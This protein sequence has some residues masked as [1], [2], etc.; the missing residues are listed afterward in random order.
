MRSLVAALVAALALVACSSDADPAPAAKACT[1]GA[2]QVCSG[3]GACVG[4]QACNAEGTAFGAC[5]C[6]AAGGAGAGGSA[7]GG[8]EAGAGGAAGAGGSGLAGA[9]GSSGAAGEPACIALAH[10]CGGNDNGCC[11][12][13]HCA[14]STSTCIKD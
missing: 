6:G 13:L 1:P 12:G 8:G 9:G 4:A 5:E 3:P 11:I 7:G 14:P 2:T 10:D